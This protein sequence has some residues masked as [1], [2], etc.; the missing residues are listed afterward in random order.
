MTDQVDAI[1]EALAVRRPTVAAHSRRVAAYSVL[2]ANQYGLAPDTVE[3]IRVGCLLHDVGKLMVP[4]HILDKPGRLTE[5]EWQVLQGHAEHGFE[6][7][8]RLGFDETVTDIVLSHHER[9]DSSGYPS[10]LGTPL[11][12]WPVR[13]V[14]VM[15]AFDALT[16][17]RPYR[18]ALSIDA[19]RTLLARES[20]DRHCP[21]VVSG[22]LSLP[23]S[24][25]E[26][27]AARESGGCRPDECPSPDTLSGATTPWVAGY[28]EQ[29]AHLTGW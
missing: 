23:K 2:L 4:A 5:R 21:W 20:A 1:L 17:P 13:I 10:G 16:S 25:L 3:A 22:L 29:P 8:R 19:A 9:G 18:E 15:D 24:L 26:A 6:I 28:V 12:P 11:I 27:V 14:A 7:A